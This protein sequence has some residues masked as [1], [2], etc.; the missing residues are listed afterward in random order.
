MPTLQSALWKVCYSRWRTPDG[1][2]QPGYTLLVAVPGDLPVFLEIALAVTGRLNPEHLVETLVLPD[3][4]TPACAAIVQRVAATWANG[5]LRLVQLRWLDRRVTE[6]L[7]KPHSNHWL[8][9]VNGIENARS[10]HALLHDADLFIF[11]RDSLKRQYETCTERGLACLGV[12]PVWDA[13]FAERGYR[14]AATWE[15]MFEIAWARSFKPWWHIG[16]D[17]VLHGEPHTFDTT[18]LPQC[19]TPPERIDYQEVKGGFVH[20]NYVISTYRWFQKSRDTFEDEHFRLL[21]VRLLIEA[22]DRSGWEYE[23]PP[24]AGL[25]KG[26]R[27]PANRVT[28]R[29]AETASHYPEFRGKLQELMASNLLSPAQAEA[30]RAGVRPFDQAYGW[31]E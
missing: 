28:Y 17:N 12:T 9:L 18:L 1:P 11:D 29:K 30:M 3:H 26:L 4:G 31:S 15:L 6:I 20:F 13:W 10:T 5:P 27:D 23:V 2:R 22:F 14:L 8:Q 24:L 21:L 25:E 7:N 16:H 19:H